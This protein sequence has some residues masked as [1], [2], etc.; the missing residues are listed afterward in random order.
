MYGIERKASA[1][2]NMQALKRLRMFRK[3]EQR[4]ICQVWKSRGCQSLQ[5]RKGAQLKDG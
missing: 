4:I 1:F 5:L 2:T 3:E